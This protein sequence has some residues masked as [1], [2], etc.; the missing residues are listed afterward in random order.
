MDGL[1]VLFLVV[2]SLALLGVA[3]ILLGAETRVGF[4]D[5]SLGSDIAF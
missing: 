2:A 5:R 3:A 1:L 4:E